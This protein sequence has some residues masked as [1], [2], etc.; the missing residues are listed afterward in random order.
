MRVVAGRDFHPVDEVGLGR[1]HSQAVVKTCARAEIEHDLSELAGH[2][3]VLPES[4]GEAD[5]L[6]RRSK[7]ASQF[8]GLFVA[9]VINDA[10]VRETVFGMREGIAVDDRV[11]ENAWVRRCESA[12]IVPGAPGGRKIGGESGS[13][14]SC[15]QEKERK[16]RALH[17][18]EGP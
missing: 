6:R 16:G 8:E 12:R 13:D 17:D 4:S 9:E 18:L 10:K 14:E 1:L 5:E 7:T 2:K 3:T 15:E 11:I